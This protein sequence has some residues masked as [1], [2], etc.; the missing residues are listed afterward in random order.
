M[1][2]VN[3]TP[4]PLYPREGNPVTNHCIGGWVGRRAGLDGCGKC[5]HHRLWNPGPYIEWRVAIP[6]ELFCISL[7]VDIIK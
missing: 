7:G 2:V 3:A 5:R 4:R 1:C 6:T